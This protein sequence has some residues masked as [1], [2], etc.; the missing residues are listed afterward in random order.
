MHFEIWREYYKKRR[1][2]VLYLTIVYNST[3]EKEKQWNFFTHTQRDTWNEWW[4]KLVIIFVVTQ[5]GSWEVSNKSNAWSPWNSGWE[6]KHSFALSFIFDILLMWCCF[7]NFV[8]LCSLEIS[9]GKLT[10]KCMTWWSNLEIPFEL[11][12]MGR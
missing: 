11:V 6:S 12:V 1:R 8:T 9:S 2:K 7:F 10:R 4:F 5:D 3:L